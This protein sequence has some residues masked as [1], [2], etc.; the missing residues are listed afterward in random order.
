MPMVTC[1]ETLSWA[2]AA[3]GVPVGRYMLEPGLEQHV[4]RGV[5]GLA[6]RRVAPPTAWCRGSGRR[7]R[8]GC[9]CAPRS[10]ATRAAS[11]RRW[12]GRG[13]RARA[14]ARRPAGSAA[15]SSGAAPGGRRS[16]RRRTG[17]SPCGR[18][19]DR[20]AAGRPGSPLRVYADSGSTA[21]SLASR[22]A[23]VRIAVEVSS[24]VDVVEREQ[25]DQ[26]GRVGLV[27]VHAGRPD[28]RRGRSGRHRSAGR[29]PAGSAQ[30][31]VTVGAVGV[32]AVGAVGVRGVAV[33]AVASP[34]PSVPSA[35]PPSVP[36]A[37]PPPGT[38]SLAG[39]GDVAVV[40]R[41]VEVFVGH[42]VLLL[43]TGRVETA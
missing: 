28:L 24:V 9:R 12:P 43:E 29:A 6:G 17:R 13:G 32:V 11:G 3:W 27:H 31:R 14:P 41:G 22:T 10:P 2:R 38:G 23:G 5:S 30:A 35:S 20:S 18:R 8:R 33:G 42:A 40:E 15:A 21:P 25:A 4:S 36:S 16:R 1:S 7:T 26:V 37:S 34:S 39:A 19:P